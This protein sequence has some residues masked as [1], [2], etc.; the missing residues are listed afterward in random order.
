MSSAIKSLLAFLFCCGIPLLAATPELR[1]CADPNNLPYSN[2]Q[3]Q[4]FENALATLAG[5]DLGM[6]VSYFW[7]PQRHK[8]FRN[9]L[10]AGTCDVVME[11]PTG[12]DVAT[13]T[14]PY[15][16]STYVFVSRRNN[17]LRIRSFDDPRLRNLRIGVPITGDSDDELPTT[18]ALLRRGLARNL[19]GYSIFGKLSEQ[20]P[21][22]D[23]VRAV[24]DKQVDVAVVWGP[25]GGYFAE[26]SSPPLEATPVCV[27]PMDQQI[28]LTFNI[29][30]GVRLGDDALRDKLNDF[31]LRRRSDIRHLLDSYAVPLASGPKAQ[32]E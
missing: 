8:F 11:V 9:T 25:L 23:I 5:R 27:A 28:P 16:R 14:I 30:M 32:C 12:I 3:R 19:Y 1:V 10:Q 20:N 18:T 6:N 21:A 4:G 26:H 13:T 24:A 17:D 2:Q 22:A 31:I 29:S 15:Y 7:F